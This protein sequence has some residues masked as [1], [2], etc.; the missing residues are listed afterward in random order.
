MGLNK[1]FLVVDDS[2]M[3]RQLILM[4]LKKMGC[5]SVVDASNGRV[6]LEKLSA[7]RID[8]VLTDIDMPEMNGLEFIERARTQYSDL[9]IVIIS[10]HGDEVTRD[11]GLMLGANDYLTKPLSGSKLSEVL[12]RLFPDLTFTN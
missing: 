2:A 1:S 9:P 4:T 3:M 8:I 5:T 7:N 6:A 10:A 11:K 12:E